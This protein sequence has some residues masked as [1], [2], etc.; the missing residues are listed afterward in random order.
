MK[1]LTEFEKGWIIGL[2]EGEGSCCATGSYGRQYLRFHIQMTDED[3]VVRVKDML[4]IGHLNVL[5]IRG[6]MTKPAYTWR[7]QKR[8]EALQF[9]KLLNGN[10]SMRRQQQLDKA[11]KNSNLYPAWLSLIEENL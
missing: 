8:E 4:K 3:T 11:I 1:H 10:L 7:C 5:E 2:Y 9:A 6:L